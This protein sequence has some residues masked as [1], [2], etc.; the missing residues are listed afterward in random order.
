MLVK[1][2]VCTKHS[3]Y[4]RQVK[5]LKNKGM[6]VVEYENEVCIFNNKKQIHTVEEMFECICKY[7]ESY[8]RDKKI[9]TILK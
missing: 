6:F 2:L 3:H 7:R 9:Q 8:L 5:N 4:F 1:K